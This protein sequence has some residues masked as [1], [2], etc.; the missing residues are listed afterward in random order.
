MS[1]IF[2]RQVNKGPVSLQRSIKSNELKTSISFL[3]AK[4]EKD[5]ARM[6]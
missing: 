6:L 3:I 1:Y 4:V 5:V 2:K